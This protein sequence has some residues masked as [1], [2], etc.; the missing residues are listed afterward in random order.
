M[1][2]VVFGMAF[3]A[4]VVAACG[5]GKAASPPEQSASNTSLVTA[6]ALG[7]AEAERELER[8]HEAQE[9]P[10]AGPGVGLAFGDRD[11]TRTAIEQM[12]N[13]AFDALFKNSLFDKAIDQLPL[14][15]APLD[16]RQWVTI[17]PSYT[18]DTL[19]QRK[20]FYRMSERQQ[21]QLLLRKPKHTL[22]ARVDPDR[23]YG[24]TQRARE[25][26]VESFYRDAQKA[27]E[28]QG[29]RDFTLVVT[30]LTETV[31]DLPALAVGRGDSTSLTALG[32]ARS[33]GGV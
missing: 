27:F 29:I 17:D 22:Y 20:R 25:L 12:Q 16:V 4:L 11:R 8:R 28:G 13:R 5:G 6:Q 33:A 30:P 9:S 1:L 14:R 24:M 15:K 21:A 23:F 19:A 18:L 3:A 32:R 31:G 10:D 2:L 26:A 7:S